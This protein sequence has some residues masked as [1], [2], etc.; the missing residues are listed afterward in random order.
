VGRLF[1]VDAGACQAVCCPGGGLPGFRYAWPGWP[2]GTGPH[3]AVP[4][5]PVP[6]FPRSPRWCLW[7]AKSPLDGTFGWQARAAGSTNGLA[8]ASSGPARHSRCGHD[9]PPHHDGPAHPSRATGIPARF[10]CP[11]RHQVS[12]PH[13]LCLIRDDHPAGAIVP[14]PGQRGLWPPALDLI[15]LCATGPGP[16]RRHSADTKAYAR[17]CR[18][19]PQ[20]GHPAPPSHG[21][22]RKPARAPGWVS[23]PRGAGRFRRRRRNPGPAPCAA[24]TGL[25][26]SGR[27]TGGRHRLGL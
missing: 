26:L 15:E 19:K 7:V 6:P 20:G 18:T 27:S 24:G 1:R 21:Q 25:P 2:A 4:R 16:R 14:G 11:I 22:E 13:P 9:G 8:A 5:F 12:G 10:W 17:K 23:S 3:Q